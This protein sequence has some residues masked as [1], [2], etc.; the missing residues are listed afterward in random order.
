VPDPAAQRS[1][2]SSGE[3][4]SI[5]RWWRA[6]PRRGLLWVEV[7]LGRGGPG[8]WPNR[9]SHRRIDA[10]HLPGHSDRVVR[11]WGADSVGFAAAVT[12]AEIELVEAKQRLN[13]DLIGQCIAGVDMFSRAYP[14]H[15]LLVPV[16]VIRGSIDLALAWVCNR[17]GILSDHATEQ[18]VQHLRRHGT[19]PELTTSR[20]TNAGTDID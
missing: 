12:G 6:H 19:L 11:D 18:D 8:A 1:F 3:D 13:V 2:P 20:S 14:D 15:G 9:R 10:V 5:I 17:R 7:E 4:W 16:A